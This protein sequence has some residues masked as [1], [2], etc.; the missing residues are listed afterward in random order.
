MSKIILFL[1][2]TLFTIN[3][4]AQNK[5]Y[6]IHN[7]IINDQH[8]TF[9]TSFYTNNF[10]LFTAPKKRLQITNKYR[11]NRIKRRLARINKK[12]KARLLKRIERRKTSILRSDLEF[13]IGITNLEGKII[14]SKLIGPTVNSKYD[15]LDAVFTKNLKT[16]Y[17][18]RNSSRKKSRPHLEIYKADV[19][20]PSYWVNIK[21]LAFNSELYSVGHPT[22]SNDGRTLYFASN[23]ESSIGSFDIF[24]VKITGENT[25]SEP[26][27]LGSK[28]NTINEETTPFIKDNIL[29]FSSNGRNG[30]GNLDIYSINLNDNSEAINIGKPFNSNKNDLSFKIIKNNKSGFFTSNRING[31]GLNDIYSFYKNVVEIEDEDEVEVEKLV[32]ETPIIKNGLSLKEFNRCQAELDALNN[33]LFDYDSSYI[34]A[35]AARELDNVISIMRKCPNIEL[36][37]TSHTDSRSSHKYN[38]NLSQRRAEETVIYILKNGHFSPKKV[39]GIGYG[40]T[41]L[42]NRCADGIK[43]STAEH[44]INRRTEFE[45]S[46]FY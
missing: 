26:I 22:L 27:N 20:T 23:M 45:I 31:K 33:I 32:P 2:I 41:R 30:L 43:C 13:Y 40:E 28:V 18:T 46:N 10:I 7:S 44:Q 12:R 34:R 42:K 38:K 36:L 6:S 24:K 9:G 5:E 16:V 21:K 25:F 35:D 37:V 11:Q 15:E 39:K 4:N 17:F 3:F 19:I 14:K 29:Y 8:S 1:L